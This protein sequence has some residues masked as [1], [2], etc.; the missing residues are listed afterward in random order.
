MPPDG[1][2]TPGG[3]P[4]MQTIMD[5]GLEE[6]WRLSNWV[7]ARGSQKSREGLCW[8]VQVGTRVKEASISET[9]AAGDGPN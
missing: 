2:V 1:T 7:E 3:E 6:G 5:C 8:L 9:R 4:Q